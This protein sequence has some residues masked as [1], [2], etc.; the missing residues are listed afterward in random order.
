[1]VL[2][3]VPLRVQ[4]VAPDKFNVPAWLPVAIV[5]VEVLP[6][7]GLDVVIL[8]ADNVPACN[9]NSGLL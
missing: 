9:S 4:G 7:L 3:P 1:M 8:L 2:V 6:A 5:T